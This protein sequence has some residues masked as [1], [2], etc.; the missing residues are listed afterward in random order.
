VGQAEIT[1][2]GLGEYFERLFSADT[3]R[4]LKPAPEPYRMVV[5]RLEVAIGELR[6]VA[7]H[8]WDIAG[9]LHAGCAGAF[10]ARPGMALDPLFDPPD[11]TG[12]DLREVAERILEREH[13]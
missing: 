10:I 1:N 4:R 9:A 2:A 7:A 8:A 13:E 5:E 11:V 12:T 6:L 3:A